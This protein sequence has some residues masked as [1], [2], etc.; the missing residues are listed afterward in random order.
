MLEGLYSAAAGMAAQQTRLDAVAN[1]LANASTPGYRPVRVAFRDLVPQPAGQGALGGVRTGAGAAASFAGRASGQGPVLQTGRTLD[2]A[3][4]G[5]GF[6]A[7]RTR[8]GDL[9]LTRAGSLNVDARGELVTSSGERL[10]PPVRLPRGTREDQVAIGPDGTVRVGERRAGRLRLVD[11]PAPAGLR[12]AG[13]SLLLPTAA[14][15]PVRAATGTTLVQGALEGSGTDV[16]SAM[17]D[18]IESQ[19]AFSLASRA[20]TTQ[21]Q[22]LE[23][24]NGV[25]R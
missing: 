6:L 4:Q 3:L 23:I 16:A 13:D 10:D 17:V 7:V 2:V 5:P 24:A 20:I 9:A 11:V 12:S 15:G 14:S 19:R 18:L 22:I 21:D 8:E 25:K 1:D